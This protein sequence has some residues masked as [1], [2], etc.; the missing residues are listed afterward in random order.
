[1][2]LSEISPLFVDHFKRKGFA[3][4]PGGSLLHPSIP[5]TFVMSAGLAQVESILN[6][7]SEHLPA[8]LV[9]SQIC[10]R[11]FDVQSIGASKFHLTLFEMPAAFWFENIDRKEVISSLW[12]FLTAVLNIDPER[13]WITY[14]SEAGIS[15]S[16]F[17][18][19]TEAE[20]AWLDVGLSSSRIIGRGVDSNYWKQG[21]G[22]EGVERYRK[23]GPNTEVFYDFGEN[24]A[25]GEDCLPGWTC[26]RFVEIANSLFVNSYL[27][28]ETNLINPLNMPF[29]ETVVGA[30]RIAMVI[31]NKT[32][33]F[34]IDSIEP[35]IGVMTIKED[36]AVIS[37]RVIVD[38]LRSLVFLVAHG[39]PPPGKDGRRKIVKKLIRGAISHMICLG[40][41]RPGVLPMLVRFIVDF[42]KDADIRVSSQEATLLSY[43][44]Q[45]SLRYEKT[46]ERGKRKFI[47]FIAQSLDGNLTTDQMDC[48]TSKYGLHPILID[49]HL[50]IQP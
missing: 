15:P 39:A 21:A 17:L 16:H 28:I 7:S 42:Y 26:G 24:Y 11:H 43:L 35:I 20:Q 3:S 32:S 30:E 41:W 31:Q 12:Q 50:R 47:Q 27:D 6:S 45:E 1:M 49:H 5:M 18:K 34:D 9:F 22:F 10:F 8:K 19:D 29:C 36:D 13:I 2:Q 48:L 4:L 37:E 14:F 38:H 25:C 40:I 33:V 23:L 46:V 44:N